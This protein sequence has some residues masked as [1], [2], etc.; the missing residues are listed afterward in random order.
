LTGR[1][2]GAGARPAENIGIFFEDLAT[3]FLENS[4]GFL[5]GWI[6]TLFVGIRAAANEVVG[7]VTQNL[8]RHPILG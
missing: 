2:W 4:N 1:P 6:A 8:K 5:L 3:S 7:G